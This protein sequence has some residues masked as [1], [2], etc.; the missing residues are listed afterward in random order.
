[1]KE[2]LM[3]RRDYDDI[4]KELEVLKEIEFS[5]EQNQSNSGNSITLEQLL[6]S[7]NK[8]LQTEFTALKVKTLIYFFFRAKKKRVITSN[9]FIFRFN[10][11][12]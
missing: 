5:V 12:K 10:T 2:K 6:I 8:R 7:K 9:F 4:K 11:K 3:E 1:M